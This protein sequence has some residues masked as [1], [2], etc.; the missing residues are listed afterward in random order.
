MVQRPW[1]A[2]KPS[3]AL[4]LMAVATTH[5]LPRGKR[6]GFVCA[7]GQHH[8]NRGGGK[9]RE[10]L[11]HIGLRP[12][13][14]ARRPS[15]GLAG[16][17]PV[18]ARQLASSCSAGKVYNKYRNGAPC[19]SPDFSVQPRST[20]CSS[21]L[22]GYM[23]ILDP[24]VSACTSLPTTSPKRKD[25]APNSKPSSLAPSPCTPATGRVGCA[26]VCAVCA[27]G[28]GCCYVFARANK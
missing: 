9:E 13:Q 23:R 1:Q 6:C 15:A 24:V 20:L 21:A 3:G 27:G 8:C 18:P 28:E 7:P 19:A 5:D 22:V 17:S 12:L 4:P 16:L 26:Y 2:D 14:T 10:R 25:V 11:E